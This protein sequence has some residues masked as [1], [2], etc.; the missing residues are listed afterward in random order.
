MKAT[1]AASAL[2]AILIG[3]GGGAVRTPGPRPL[4]RIRPPG[5]RIELLLPPTAHRV[6]RALTYVDET[7]GLA[8]F[9]VDA[10]VARG[11]ERLLADHYGARVEGRAGRTPR[12]RSLSDGDCRA[13]DGRPLACEGIEI[14]LTTANSRHRVLSLWHRGAV[15][16]AAVVHRGRRGAAMARRIVRSIR[17]YP[18]D[19]IEPHES[20]S[21]PAPEVVDLQRLR[22]SSD[23][24]SYRRNPQMDLSFPAAEPA[25]DV[26]AE[27]FFGRPPGSNSERGAL[28]G[29]WMHFVSLGDDTELTPLIDGPMVGLELQ[30]RHDDLTI[31]GAYLEDESGCLLLRGSTRDRPDVWIPRFRGLAQALADGAALGPRADQRNH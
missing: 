23:R 13:Q 28:L 20:L 21:L 14:T 16:R 26:A 18:F 25:I 15:V 10:N 11:R 24:L 6:P 31:Y 29:R 3:C 17:Y 2:V 7:N 27:P 8:L 4:T 9:I 22:L 30:G 12:M 19:E 5:S 1:V